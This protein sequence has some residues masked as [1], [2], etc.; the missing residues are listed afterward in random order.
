MRNETARSY[1][2][3]GWAW[4]IETLL[5][6]CVLDGLVLT[7]SAGIA[8]GKEAVA[9]LAGYVLIYVGT[10]VTACLVDS[11]KIFAPAVCLLNSDFPLNARMP[12]AP[13]PRHCWSRLRQ[14]G[15]CRCRCK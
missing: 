6:F 14:T 1:R 15:A 7:Y 2:L 12:P 9:F 13:R 8:T 11:G 5:L 10:I 4:G 3:T